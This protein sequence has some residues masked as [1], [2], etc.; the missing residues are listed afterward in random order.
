MAISRKPKPTDQDTVDIEALI[1]K[2]GSVAGQEAPNSKAKLI[3]VML[4][5]PPGML[6][7]VD[8]AVQARAVPTPRTTWIMEA[9]VEKLEREGHG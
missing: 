8:A 9:I 4:R 1:R 6:D 5:L 3:P 2:G 7:K